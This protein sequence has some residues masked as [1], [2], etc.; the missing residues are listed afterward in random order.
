M[1]VKCINNTAKVLMNYPKK[2][3]G[4]SENSKYGLLEIGKEYLVMGIIT[5]EGML[6]Y[7]IDDSGIISTCA[8]QLFDIIDNNL[9]SNWFFKAY[10]NNDDVY[11][12]REAIWGYYELCNDVNH[13]EQLIEHEEVALHI[14]FRRKVEI[15]RNNVSDL[16]LLK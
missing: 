11:P 5:G 3:L 2:P 6:N 14:Y 15:E 8:Y 10:T 1:K 7:L 4:I 9:P 16:E 12:Y 13:Y